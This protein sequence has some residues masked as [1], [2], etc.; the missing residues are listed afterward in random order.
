MSINQKISKIPFWILYGILAS[1]IIWDFIFTYLTIKNNP[2]MGEGNPINVFF[3]QAFGL[4]Y[5]LWSIPII[6]ILIYGVIRLG[7]WMVVNIDKRPDLNGKNHV[8]IMCILL[9]FPNVL[10]EIIKFLFGVWVIKGW[11]LKYSLVSGVAL[12]VV[13][14]ILTEYVSKKK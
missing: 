3:I 11:N 1:L 13:Y 10:R 8:A 14:I 7:A 4:E 12:M 2:H 5:F 6:L 9:V